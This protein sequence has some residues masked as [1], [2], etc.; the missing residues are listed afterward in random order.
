MLPLDV[1]CY[2]LLLHVSPC[3]AGFLGSGKTTLVRHILSADHNFR[4]A[5][6]VNEYG[7]TAGIESA[8]VTNDQVRQ[9]ADL[10]PVEGLTSKH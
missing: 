6:I 10:C 2:R 9:T 7:D 3:V 5:V 1:N 4:I 8:A